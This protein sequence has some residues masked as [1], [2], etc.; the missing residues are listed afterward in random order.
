LE[1]V[2]LSLLAANLLKADFLS[3]LAREF[4]LPGRVLVLG[5]VAS[6]LEVQG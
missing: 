3:Y 6:V 1:L 2:Q 4:D 5:W